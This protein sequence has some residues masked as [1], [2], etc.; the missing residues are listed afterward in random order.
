[1][2]YLSIFVILKY[3]KDVDLSD[4]CLCVSFNPEQE[5]PTGT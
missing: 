3:D 2:L 1:M 5:E 4:A